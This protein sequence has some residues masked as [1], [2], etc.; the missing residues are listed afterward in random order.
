MRGWFVGERGPHGD[1]LLCLIRRTPTAD[2][3]LGYDLRHDNFNVSK[4]V[5]LC[6]V[7]L[8]VSAAISRFT[9]R[10]LARPLTHLREGITA[11]RNGQLKPMQVSRTGDEI[12]YLE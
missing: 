6:L 8:M 4:G 7:V 9:I 10:L 3:F 11:V 5:L 1:Q 12:E 2:R